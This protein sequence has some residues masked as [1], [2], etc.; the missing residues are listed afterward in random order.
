MTKTR[1]D[2]NYTIGSAYL[3]QAQMLPSNT[4]AVATH[5]SMGLQSWAQAKTL[6]LK[7]CKS[8]IVQC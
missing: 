4:V 7:C 1:S 5:E 3:K 8:L 6:A 2:V